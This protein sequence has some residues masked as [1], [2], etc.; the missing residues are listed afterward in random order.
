[1]SHCVAYLIMCFSQQSMQIVTS[2]CS[3]N[4]PIFLCRDINFL[5]SCVMK[6][7]LAVKIHG[8]VDLWSSKG[9]FY[10]LLNVLQT[11]KS[12]CGWKPD[13]LLPILKYYET[14]QLHCRNSARWYMD[15]D[16]ARQAAVSLMPRQVHPCLFHAWSVHVCIRHSWSLYFWPTSWTNW[17]TH[18]SERS[19]TVVKSKA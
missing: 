13:V 19:L 5:E 11:E 1:M 18:C 6:Y 7:L 12:F 16:D 14:G 17:N 8:L 2:P 4:T 9:T 3:L 15:D 10:S